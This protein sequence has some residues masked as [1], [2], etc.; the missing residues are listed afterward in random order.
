MLGAGRRKG[1][2][3]SIHCLRRPKMGST[4][5]DG[6]FSL[7]NTSPLRLLLANDFEGWRIKIREIIEARP[8]WAIVSEASDGQQ[9]LEKAQQFRP[10]VVLLDI[11]MPVMDGLQAA[12]EIRRVCPSSK[13]IFVTY[14]SDDAVRRAALEIGDDYILKDN[15]LKDLVATVTE[16]FS[17]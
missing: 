12:R 4:M 3:P 7:P 13:I 17:P 6:P 1:P 11:Q 5:K 2:S 8:D 16:C 9:A 14:T 10:D 15:V